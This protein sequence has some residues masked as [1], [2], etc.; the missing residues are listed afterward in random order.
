MS[1]DY[2]DYINIIGNRLRNAFS[3]DEFGVEEELQ[4]WALSAEHMSRKK[5]PTFQNIINWVD[6][7]YQAPVHFLYKKEGENLILSKRQLITDNL[8][9]TQKT[10]LKDAALEA[11]R[12]QFIQDFESQLQNLEKKR[13][14]DEDFKEHGV[15]A[16]TI[17][18]CEHIP[19]YKKNGEFWGIYVVGPFL[20]SPINM[21]PKFSIV[22]RLLARWLIELDEKEKKSAQK[23]QNEISDLVGELG[24]GALNTEAISNLFLLYLMNEIG[25]ESGAIIE[26]LNEVPAIVVSKNINEI[27]QSSL[28]GSNG[29]PFYK[30]IDDGVEATPFGLEFEAK[31]KE[32][33]LCIPYSNN[34]VK[35]YIILYNESNSLSIHSDEVTE[36]LAVTVSQLLE[37]RN[38]NLTFSEALMDTY[39]NMVRAIELKREKTKYHSLRMI[40]FAE[41]FGMLF[42]LD[43][44]ESNILKQTA[45]LHD[46]GYAGALGLNSVASIGSE[47]AHPLAGAIMISNLP[48][49]DDIKSGIKT[50]HEWVNGKGTPDGI[51][52]DQIPWTGKIISVFEFIVDFIESNVNVP[53]EEQEQ[54]ME[55]LKTDL[56]QRADEQFDMV[57]IPTVIQQLSMLGWQGCVDL[58]VPS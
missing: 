35:G 50:H 11:Q 37:F 40:A 3:L 49:H 23:Y 19:L 9:N 7:L 20:K 2:K 51:L 21:A 8:L 22:S 47:L 13:Q 30:S 42:G 41:M 44:N 29:K 32:K 56:I 48:I 5:A 27:I 1:K 38:T 53:K 28:D 57:I 55:K 52:G 18:N 26:Y 4:F 6:L 45:K 36:Q 14:W 43:V 17:G 16:H 25:A 54:M 33:V 58:G 10:K 24:S 39:F 46:I 12:A 15:S 34:S 31:N